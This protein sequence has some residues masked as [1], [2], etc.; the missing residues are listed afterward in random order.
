MAGREIHRSRSSEKEKK[1]KRRHRSSSSSSSS[2]SERGRSRRYTY[3]TSTDDSKFRIS[4]ESCRIL[5]NYHRKLFCTWYALFV[6]WN[7]YICYMSFIRKSKDKK[8]RKHRSSSSSSSTSSSSASSSSSSSSDS[9]HRK[10]N[11][12]KR[13]W[14]RYTVC[15][16]LICLCSIQR[17]QWYLFPLSVTISENS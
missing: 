10:G 11:K 15:F 4:F 2:S 17:Y 16:L 14:V 13:K 5:L 6:A 1:A 12:R 3:N 7:D 8:K 9:R